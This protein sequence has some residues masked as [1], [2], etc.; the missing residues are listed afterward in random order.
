MKLHIGDIAICTYPESEN[1]DEDIAHRYGC[2]NC[3]CAALI[4]KAKYVHEGGD[5][6]YN[7]YTIACVPCA[8]TDDPADAL[9][10]QGFLKPIPDDMMGMGHEA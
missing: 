1:Y 6:I 3:N 4:V 7:T 8:C 5:N 10:Y 2:K 9:I